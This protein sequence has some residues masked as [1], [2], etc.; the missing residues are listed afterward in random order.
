MA[1]PEETIEEN[2]AAIHVSPAIFRAFMQDLVEKNLYHYQP[3]E[4][5]LEEFPFPGSE[6][7]V[8]KTLGLK[9]TTLIVGSFDRNLFYGCDDENDKRELV[10]DYDK[11]AGSFYVRLRWNSGVQTAFPDMVVVSV[12]SETPDVP[13]ESISLNKSA[14]S[15]VKDATE[16]LVATVL[17][18]DATDPSVSWSSNDEEVAT[19]SDAG[20]VTAVAVGVA[21][22]IAKAGDKIAACAVTVTA[23]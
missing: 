22:I 20:V 16:A 23:E 18:V 8:V 3:G 9:G 14:T 12:V 17:P 4:A 2:T 6:V 7:K 1:L 11:K 13:V 15:I 21:V 19:V 5:E 10:I